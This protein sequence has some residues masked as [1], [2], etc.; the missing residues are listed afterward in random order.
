M[1]FA[2]RVENIP[3]CLLQDEFRRAVLVLLNRFID[4]STPETRMRSAASRV[5]SLINRLQPNYLRPGEEPEPILN[6]ALKYKHKYIHTQSLKPNTVIVKIPQTPSGVV[7]SDKINA[8]FVKAL[9]LFTPVINRGELI[10]LTAHG[11]LSTE[12]YTEFSDADFLAIFRDKCFTTKSSMHL[13]KKDIQKFNEFIRSIDPLSHHG[14]SVLSESDLQYYDESF[15]PI[16]QLHL[17]SRIFG[18][19]QIGFGLR[20][21]RIESG[22]QLLRHALGIRKEPTNS[23]STKLF[24]SRMH[25]IPAIYLQCVYGL[26]VD[27]K[28][29][30]DIA[31]SVFP[32]EQT[33]AI[34]I[35]SSLREIWLKHNPFNC[36]PVKLI[37]SALNLSNF[38]LMKLET[39][40]QFLVKADSFQYQENIQNEFPSI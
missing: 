22:R 6:N 37:N 32:S 3:N 40:A 5:T 1:L 27:K 31:S 38:C 19:V 35:A 33:E 4:P 34:E 7:R 23:Y 18:P 15:L 2:D 20:N 13:L 24:L 11:S 10:M 28:T 12:D 8:I 14:L 17:S 36:L 21:C 25:L 16:S 39:V 26:Y 29:A 30:I 9:E